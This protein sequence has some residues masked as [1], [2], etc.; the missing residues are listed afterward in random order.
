MAC[1]QHPTTERQSPFGEMEDVD[2]GATEAL[3]QLVLS[4]PRNLYSLNLF[5][6][7][8]FA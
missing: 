7:F 2:L 6:F 8:S 1:D 4:V 5:T 3:S